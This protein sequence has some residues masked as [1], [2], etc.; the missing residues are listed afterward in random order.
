MATRLHL[1]G[2]FLGAGKT[3]L[4]LKAAQEL[5]KK[6]YRVG[7]VTNDQAQ[8]LVDTAMARHQDIPVMEVAGGCFCC[9][10]P[11]LLAAVE[12]LE[13]EVHP[14]IILSEPVGSCTDLVSTI[15]RPLSAYYATQ[16]QVAPLTVLVDPLRDP[17]SFPEEV[18]YIYDKQLTEANII[19]ISKSDLLDAAQLQQHIQKLQGQYPS[20][21]VM[22]LSAKTG[23]GIGAWLDQ[24]LQQTSNTERVMEM[25]YETYAQGEAY[26]GWLNARG[27]LSGT[28]PFS[29]KEWI[30]R[31]LSAIEQECVQN[32]AEI[33]HLKLHVIAEMEVWKVSLTQLGRPATWDLA[34]TDI[35]TA[36]ASF[37]VNA[38]VNTTP[39]ILEALIRGV[40]SEVATASGITADIEELACFSPLP[41]RPTHRLLEV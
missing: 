17:A 28:S 30:T 25:N 12:R 39:L 32:N 5:A 27:K 36:V 14:D 16:F 23:V 22:A 40:F 19:V 26:L 3:T 29:P 20:A 38:R 35:Q 4:L 18:G 8:D 10:F 33:A 21:Q 15:F 6:G 1:V 13:Q 9:R 24:C 7:M 31:V 41:P 11:D 2:G 37:I 34:P